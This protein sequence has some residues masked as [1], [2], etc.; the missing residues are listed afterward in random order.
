MQRTIPHNTLSWTAI[1]SHV[2]MTIAFG[3]MLFHSLWARVVFGSYS[4]VICRLFFLAF[5][6][7]YLSSALGY[8]L[9]DFTKVG[10]PLH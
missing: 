8:R 5:V 2:G 9:S 6:L 1:P 3:Y 4:F 10:Y 7:A